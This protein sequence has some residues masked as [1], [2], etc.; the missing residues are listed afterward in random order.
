[1]AGLLAKYFVDA[2]RP[3]RARYFEKF[4]KLQGYARTI[5]DIPFKF[6][7]HLDGRGIKIMFS[8]EEI[9][10]EWKLWWHV[11]WILTNRPKMVS[12]EAALKWMRFDES[13]RIKSKV[14]PMSIDQI[15]KKPKNSYKA[16]RVSHPCLGNHTQD[17]KADISQ[18]LNKI[19]GRRKMW[20]TQLR[21]RP[22]RK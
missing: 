11:K 5:T 22:R 17:H 19:V 12:A 16:G 14:E 4:Q 8:D 6:E 15:N 18:S 2:K 9:C 21:S 7:N 13:T 10:P 1:M 20:R 3:V